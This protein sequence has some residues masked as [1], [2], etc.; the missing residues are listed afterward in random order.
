MGLIYITNFSCDYNEEVVAQFYA[1]LYVDDRRKVMHFTLGGKRFSIEMYEFASLFRLCG[2]NKTFYQGRNISD[3]D[4]DLVRLHEVKELEVSKIHF[5][6]DKAYRRV[7]FGCTHGLTPYYKLLHQLFRLILTPRA[8]GP[9]N[10][11]HRAKDLLYQMAPSQCQFNVCDFLW[12]E[13]ITCSHDPSSGCH[14]AP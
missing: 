7:R 9:A 14:Y 3:F 10:I 6:Y 13:I 2:V 8:G 5:M 12:Q 4:H 1:T 11:S